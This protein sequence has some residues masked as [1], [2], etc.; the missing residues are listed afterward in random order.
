MMRAGGT[1]IPIAF[2]V[3]KFMTSWNLVGCSVARSAFRIIGIE[4]SADTFLIADGGGDAVI[5]ALGDLRSYTQDL[6]HPRTGAA[7]ALKTA[8]VDNPAPEDALDLIEQVQ[9]RL[10]TRPRNDSR[11]QGDR[12]AG[13]RPPPA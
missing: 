1:V 12:G 7:F 2:A 5:D 13:V 4:D 9:L 6:E 8:F 11:G 10:Y 3:L